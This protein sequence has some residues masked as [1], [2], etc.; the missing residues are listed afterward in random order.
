MTKTFRLSGNAMDRRWHVIDAKGRPL[1][2][3]ASEVAQ[4][5]MGKHKPTYTPHVDTGD[6][7]VVINAEKVQFSG[8]KWQQKMYRWY[9]GYQGLRS[10]TAEHRR[11]RNP[12]L[13][14]EEAVRRMLPKSRLGRVMLDKLKIY[15]GAE[16]PHQAQQPQVMVAGVK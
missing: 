13:I 5:L 9:T 16:H 1:G 8:K 7:I 10:E 14:V 2:R 6:F 11:D 3:V 4:L 15:A 12:E